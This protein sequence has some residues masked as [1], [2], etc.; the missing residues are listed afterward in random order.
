MEIKTINKSQR[1]TTLKIENLAKRSGDIEASTTNNVEDTK[2]NIYTIVKK[3]KI[4]L[5]PKHPE[6]AGH[7]EKIKPKNNTYKREQRF[8][9]DGSIYRNPS[10]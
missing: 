1:E 2:E 3:C 5:S 7:N 6:N 9:R 8:P 4:A 10:T